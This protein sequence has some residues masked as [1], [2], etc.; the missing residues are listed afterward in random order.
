M[1]HWALLGLLIGL[2][3]P[4]G[5]LAAETA[6]PPPQ[7]QPAALPVLRVGGETGRPPYLTG[8][9]GEPVGFEVDLMR[10][11]G[12]AMGFRPEFHP[13]PWS[14]VRRDFLEG[15]LDILTGLFYGD[16]RAQPMALSAPV[17]LVRPALVGRVPAALSR[18]EELDGR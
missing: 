4:T 17:G 14:A 6:A 7:Q 18:V 10:A 13:G 3:L 9:A 8:I 5:R 15:R 11:L 2:L 12:E 16:D 1:R